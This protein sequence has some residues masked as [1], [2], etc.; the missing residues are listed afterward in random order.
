MLLTAAKSYFIRLCTT[1]GSYMLL[2]TTI[3]YLGI[4]QNC[5]RSPR[6]SKVK[7]QNSWKFH[8]YFFFSAIRNSISFLISPWKLHTISLIPMEISYPL[9]PPCLFFSGIAH[10][11]LHYI[12]WG[13]L[14]GGGTKSIYY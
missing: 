13:G 4:L 11:A 14:G 1:Y 3:Y 5:A 8:I 6:N 7:N 12:H 2:P 9:N 10:C